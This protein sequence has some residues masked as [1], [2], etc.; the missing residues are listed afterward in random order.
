MNK[1]SETLKKISDKFKSLSKGRKIAFGVLFTSVIIAIIYL[2]IT[3]SRTEYGV[4]FAEM[5]STNAGDVITKL[6]EKKVDYKVTDG[7]STILVPK[8]QMDSMRMEI[9]SEVNISGS[10]GWEL[11]N[12]SGMVATDFENNINYQRALAGEIERSIKTFHDIKDCRVILPLTEKAVFVE[13]ESPAK[14]SVVIRLRQGV[15]ELNNNQ[16]KTIAALVAG[17]VDNLDIRDVKIAVDG[18]FLATDGI[19]EEEED[20]TSSS[21]K[22]EEIRRE[23]E[24]E[25]E[26][27]ALKLLTKSFGDGI[28]VVVSLDMNF[29]TK[30]SESVTY[31]DGILVSEQGSSNTSSTGDGNSSSSPID[32]NFTTSI[33]DS[34]NNS[35][36]SQSSEYIKNYNVPEKKEVHVEAPGKIEKMTV[37]VVVDG[38]M[39]KLD[40]STKSTIRGLVSGAVGFTPERGDTIYVGSLDFKNEDKVILNK[41]ME[42]M[43]KAE[44]LAKKEKIVKQIGFGFAAILMLI[45]LIV[46][47]KK[48]N[49]KEKD[50]FETINAANGINTVI[51]DNIEPK[52]EQQFEPINFEG[53]DEKS[54]IEK[55]VKKY[56][57][58]KPDQ[59]A[60]IVKSW[61]AED[62]G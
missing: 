30:K 56:A 46:I 50:E 12:S 2:G 4:L 22:Q 26:E 54:H 18:I 34:N 35:N 8:E 24:E 43:K 38:S 37:S 45:I 59:V 58:D 9:L 19:F 5:D 53:D 3:L 31:E 1:L 55:E 40:E 27:N 14:A 61:L 7:G 48:K 23:H 36:S 11:F 42:D 49:K 29:D 10:V 25:L 13:E 32:N 17:S 33:D 57:E 52:P 39:G 47:I 16:V 62:E 60:E 41:A 15:K 51:G 28:D 6:K 21:N 44:E 20:V